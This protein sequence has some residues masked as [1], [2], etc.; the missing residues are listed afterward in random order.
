MWHPE[1]SF[2][3]RMGSSVRER[4]TLYDATRIKAVHNLLTQVTARDRFPRS[5]A[6]HR[7][8]KPFN[9]IASPPHK[10][11]SYWS[12]SLVQSLQ[13]TLNTLI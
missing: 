7:F 3:S 12:V 10:K 4:Y 9:C 13:R 6:P 5:A 1:D 2:D 11:S 8:L